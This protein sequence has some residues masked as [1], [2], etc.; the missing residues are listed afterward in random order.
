LRYAFKEMP[1]D[2]G[3]RPRPVV[4][5]IV[6]GLT[7]SPVYCLADSGSM[8][9]R[10]ASWVADAC[11]IDLAGATEEIVGI[12]GFKTVA[13]TATARL[14]VAGLTWEAP[15]S[16]CDP[17]PRSFQLLGQQGFF[18]WFEVTIRAADLTIDLEPEDR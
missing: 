8:H 16:F 12:G 6:E 17:W 5:V 2:A 1:G 11:G 13:R 15:V 4:P 18:R 9:N 10:F 14:S 3:G 7:V